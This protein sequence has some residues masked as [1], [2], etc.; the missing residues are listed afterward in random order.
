M[1]RWGDVMN[2]TEILDWNESLALTNADDF[3]LNVTSAVSDDSSVNGSSS[4]TSFDRAALAWMLSAAVVTVVGNVVIGL[5][6]VV[7]SSSVL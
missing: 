7:T 3:T 1:S 4:W 5:M 6:M 2:A